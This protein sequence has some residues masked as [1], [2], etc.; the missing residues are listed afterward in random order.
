MSRNV[1]DEKAVLIRYAIHD[2]E[3]VL[4]LITWKPVLMGKV[5]E[6][7]GSESVLMKPVECSKL[8]KVSGNILF[9]EA[10]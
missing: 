10:F 9:L 8:E 6:A 4:V 5:Y 7:E 3:K 2:L 1:V